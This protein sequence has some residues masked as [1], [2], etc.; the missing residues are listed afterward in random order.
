MLPHSN[1]D[2]ERSL[3]INTNVVT[4][5][6]PAIGEKTINAIRMVKDIVKFSDPVKECSQSVPVNNEVFSYVKAAH[7]NYLE[8]I[9]KEKEEKEHQK[10]E[11]ER[12]HLE[13]KKQQEQRKEQQ[14][15]TMSML[16]K[17]KNLS[18]EE[19]IIRGK[20]LSSELLLSEGNS[21]LKKALEDED[22]Q[23]AS[24]AQMMISTASSKIEKLR[25]EM[26][27]LR[28]RQKEVEKGKRK[29]LEETI[30]SKKQK[31]MTNAS[32]SKAAQEP[33]SSS[34]KHK[35]KGKK[36]SSGMKK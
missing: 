18:K 34:V 19:D 33:S 13:N 10:K 3:S 4:V 6:M 26:D 31:L 25:K 23:C 2:V 7:R 20:L 14:D 22:M 15:R 12:E 27:S 11:R 29:M 28:T 1:A 21:K 30:E 35:G 8:R 24:V 32:T 17:E 5:D 9:Q 16:D 36:S